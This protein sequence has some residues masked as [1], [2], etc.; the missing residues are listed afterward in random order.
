MM[1]FW[2]VNGVWGFNL[3]AQTTLTAQLVESLKF[4][5]TIAMSQLEM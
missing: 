3:F 1:I 5:A 4:Q 2:A